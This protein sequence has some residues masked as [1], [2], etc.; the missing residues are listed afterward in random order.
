MPSSSYVVSIDANIGATKSTLIEY[1]A[2]I[3]SDK[4]EKDVE[5]VESWQPW[6]DEIYVKGTGTLEFQLKVLIERCFPTVPT[7]KTL[8]IERS[9]MFQEGV[10]IPANVH[11]GK[12]TER[13]AGLL[14]ELY[15]KIHGLWQPKYYVYLRSDPAECAKRIVKRGRRSEDAIQIKYLQD[16]HDLHEETL[17]RIIEEGKKVIVINVEGKTTKEIADEVELALELEE[18]HS[19]DK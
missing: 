1:M 17:S 3:W 4:Y 6:L 2:S 7:N 5:P 14:H 13:Q 18:A 16:L 10:F 19:H 9:P 8:L 12:L 15:A 11:N